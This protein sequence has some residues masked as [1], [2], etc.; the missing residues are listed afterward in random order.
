MPLYKWKN[1]KYKP[2]VININQNFNDFIKLT[3]IKQN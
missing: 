3:E 1:F 2:A